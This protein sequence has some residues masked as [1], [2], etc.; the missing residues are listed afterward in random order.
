MA[1]TVARSDLENLFASWDVS[2]VPP[3]RS[4]GVTSLI[5]LEIYRASPQTGAARKRLQYQL[6]LLSAW[7]P[8]WRSTTMKNMRCDQSPDLKW[9]PSCI[10]DTANTRYTLRCYKM[11]ILLYIEGYNHKCCS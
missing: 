10:L 8:I 3:A 9:I 2:V 4:A 6:W 1:I 11:D 5:E 7:E